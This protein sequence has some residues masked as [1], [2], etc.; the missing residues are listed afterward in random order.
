MVLFIN[1]ALFRLAV[2]FFNVLGD[3]EASVEQLLDIGDVVI[4]GY[5]NSEGCAHH[6]RKAALNQSHP[7]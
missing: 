4:L 7:F 5:I 2:I 6:E 3:Q 1:V